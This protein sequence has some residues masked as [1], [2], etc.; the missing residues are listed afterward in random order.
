MTNSENEKYTYKPT[1]AYWKIDLLLSNKK[2]VYVI[3][4]G[5]G[6]GKTISILM[7]II[8]LARLRPKTEISIVS[9]ELSKMKKGVVR[10]AKKI[11]QDWNIPFNYNGQECIIKFS[12]SS[13]IEFLGLDQQDVG[14]GLRRDI[15]FGNEANKFNLPEWD[16]M[17]SRAKMKI[18]D[19][20]PNE[21]FWGHDMI[22]TDNFINLT[23]LDNEYLSKEE[24]SNI[25]EYKIKGYIKSNLENYD[26]PEN[27]KNN[28]YANKWRVYGKGQ[29]AILDDI[30]FTGWKK[31][32]F[33]DYLKIPNSNEIYVCD[34]GK[35]D[36]FAISSMKVYDKNLYIH[37]LNYKS[38]NE[39]MNEMPND[40]KQ[41]FLDSN[42]NIVTYT[43]EKLG[44]PK[45]ATIICDN[46]RPNAI[47][48]L[49]KNGW[50]YASATYNKDILTGVTALQGM[51]IYYTETS[52]NLETELT[53]FTHFKDRQGI[54]KDKFIDA[55]NHLLDGVRYGWEYYFRNRIL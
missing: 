6:A 2:K 11:L 24:I 14:K 36:P 1:T 41:K 53:N 13:Y 35:V 20:N 16:E 12:N 46:A 19:F 32:S 15:V 55:Y 8:E 50:E 48:D 29:V 47:Q 33:S 44:I 34:W 37:E 45:N 18:I 38:E 3:Q 40:F 26:V 25:E 17:T 49:R 21:K 52:V 43:L 7:H 42:K 31:I 4:G 28:F 5:Q 54:I 22:E 51:N 39:I 9:K 23:Y 30:V 27:I 10:D